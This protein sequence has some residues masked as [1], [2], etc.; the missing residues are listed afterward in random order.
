MQDV[1]ELMQEDKIIKKVGQGR[2]VVI[3]YLAYVIS[4]II[5]F[6][7][8]DSYLWI[9]RAIA[10][11]IAAFIALTYIEIKTEDKRKE[12]TKKA[13]LWLKETSKYLR[14]K[15]S[16]LSRKALANK[17]FVNVM[18]ILVVIAGVLAT[19]AIG[20]ALIPVFIVVVIFV[21][22]FVMLD[23]QFW[24][25]IESDRQRTLDKFFQD[26]REKR[27]DLPEAC[28]VRF[29]ISKCKKLRNPFRGIPAKLAKY[30]IKKYP[31]SIT[32][33][34]FKQTAKKLITGKWAE[35]TFRGEQ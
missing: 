18:S 13:K 14:I 27:E 32:W 11:I 25:E 19:L 26:F 7:S 6:E 16:T 5:A 8:F 12:A 1:C 31:K 15:L 2:V 28:E 30:A 20:V 21:P 35:K 10:F 9:L 33:N 4:A 3:F 23:N 24:R 22:I 34:R 29:E 17:N